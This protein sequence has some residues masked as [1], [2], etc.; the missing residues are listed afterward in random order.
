MSFAIFYLK[1]KEKKSNRQ[2]TQQ[3][4]FLFIFRRLQL[5]AKDDILEISVK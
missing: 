4:Y 2:I 1:N 3:K 5:I